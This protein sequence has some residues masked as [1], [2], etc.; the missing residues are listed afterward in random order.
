M[1]GGLIW[2]VSEKE[3]GAAAGPEDQGL[4]QES[5]EDAPFFR[6]V[7]SLFGFDSEPES[8]PGPTRK[9]GPGQAAHTDADVDAEDAEDAGVNAPKSASPTLSAEVPAG[10]SWWSF[11][12]AP[13]TPP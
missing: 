12:S 9:L 13:R 1:P 3:N 4:E 11:D 8:G 10:S 5:A 7:S 6:R 2:P